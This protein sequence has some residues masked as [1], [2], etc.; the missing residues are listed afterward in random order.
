[1]NTSIS[2]IFFRNEEHLWDK[3]CF[4]ISLQYIHYK[5]LSNMCPKPAVREGNF[6]YVGIFP[7]RPL[8]IY[9]II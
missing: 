2:L 7:H 5:R 1:M 9:N 3:S 8:V 6:I 4:F